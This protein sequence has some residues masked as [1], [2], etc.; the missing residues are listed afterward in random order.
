MNKISFVLSGYQGLV[1]TGYVGLFLCL[2]RSLIHV[3]S[4]SNPLLK[5]EY[6]LLYRS[7]T[8]FA[9]YSLLCVCP[10]SLE[11][12]KLKVKQLLMG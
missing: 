3:K 7:G 1:N 8:D 4:K 11:F 6:T 12:H 10:H 9:K 2:F 5:L